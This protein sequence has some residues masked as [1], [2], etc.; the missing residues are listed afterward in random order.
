MQ[1]WFE[2]NGYGSFVLES[3]CN[4][5]D[6]RV[7]FDEEYHDKFYDGTAHTML[8][9]IKADH[10]EFTLS[11]PSV[12]WVLNNN[13]YGLGAFTRDGY[14]FQSGN[15]GEMWDGG[16]QLYKSGDTVRM[17]VDLDEGTVKFKWNYDEMTD[18]Y[19]P[20]MS[21]SKNFKYRVAVAMY[22]EESVTFAF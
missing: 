22:N 18:V 17:I 12:C 3:G 5:I 13:V 4:I 14:A 15:W 10:T 21:I 7:Q 11:D 20:P 16:I 8:G 2:K 9:I 1:T 6:L 19:T